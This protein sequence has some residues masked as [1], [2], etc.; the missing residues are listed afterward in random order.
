MN[1]IKV[2][3]NGSKNMALG[4]FNEEGLRRTGLDD[5]S[6]KLASEFAR[7][8]GDKML[9]DFDL[10]A[11]PREQQRTYFRTIMWASA[12]DLFGCDGFKNGAPEMQGVNASLQQHA[13]LMFELANKVGVEP[14]KAVTKKLVLEMMFR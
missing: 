12:K 11:L 1:G 2:H 14:R 8:N 5:A 9:S 7:E 10:A 13:N 6:I 4:G 3:W